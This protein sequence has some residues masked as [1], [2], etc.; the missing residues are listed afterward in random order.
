MLD[1][2][3]WLGALWIG[4]IVFLPGLLQVA[5]TAATRRARA[6]DGSPAAGDAEAPVPARR[7]D[8]RSERDVRPDAA[9]ARVVLARQAAWR[10]RC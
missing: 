6:G 5:V 8:G 9:A 10:L 1:D 2:I 4:V 3:G 7:P